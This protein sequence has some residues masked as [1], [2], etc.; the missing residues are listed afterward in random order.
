MVKVGEHGLLRALGLAQRRR[1]S[2]LGRGGT[3]STG[4]VREV[5]VGETEMGKQKEMG[6]LAVLTVRTRGFEQR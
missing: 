3:E 4:R 6:N 1:Q 2:Q 5:R